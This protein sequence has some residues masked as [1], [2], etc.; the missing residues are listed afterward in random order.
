MNSKAKKSFRNNSNFLKDFCNN[1]II[2]IDF[3]RRNFRFS[4]DIYFFLMGFKSP[5]LDFQNKFQFYMKN[6]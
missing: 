1:V 6:T 5:N 2:G 3:S 4:K